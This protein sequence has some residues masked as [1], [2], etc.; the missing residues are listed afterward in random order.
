M[1]PFIVVP[2]LLLFL[3]P[4]LSG[5]GEIDTQKRIMLRDESTFGGFV[6]SNGFAANYRYGR[7]IDVRN[8]LLFDVDLTYIRHPKEVKTVVNYI[9]FTRSYIFGKENLFWELK[10]EIGKQT[11]W[12]RKRDK[13]G[14]S[15]R[16]FYTGGLSLGFAKPVYYL[17]LNF[18]ST[19]TVI[20]SEYQ[21]YDPSI[22]QSNIGGK[23][24]FFMG[25][26]ELKL[27]PGLTAKTGFSFEYSEQDILVHAIELGCSFTLY[28]KKIPIMATEENNFFFFG[29]FVGY[30]FGNVINIS[31]AARAKSWKEKRDER[32]QLLEQQGPSMFPPLR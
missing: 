24:P 6:S 12:Y 1:K 26:N 10:G 28:P 27:V 16:F 5:Q 13:S 29:M 20:S 30:R 21:K 4:E 32:K 22:H 7:W 2:V 25:F 19:G 9:D 31:E 11:E 18:S 14:L 15:V 17:I 3:F 23:G 8:E